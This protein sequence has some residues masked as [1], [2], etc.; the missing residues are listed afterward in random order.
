M[1]EEAMKNNVQYFYLTLERDGH[2]HRIGCIAMRYDEKTEVYMLAGSMCSRQDP[3]IAK[4][5]SAKAVGRLDSKSD[6]H[7]AILHT[8]EMERAFPSDIVKILSLD[9]AHGS[10]R[11]NTEPNMRKLLGIYKHLRESKASA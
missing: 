9:Y 4:T 5:G 8:D 10:D 1:K 2:Q 3:F 11:F 6:C 7:R